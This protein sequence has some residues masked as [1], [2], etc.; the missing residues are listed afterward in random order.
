MKV[1][2]GPSSSEF[3]ASAWSDLDLQNLDVM[4]L[5]SFRTIDR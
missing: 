2:C 1:H 4:F 3:V 5:K